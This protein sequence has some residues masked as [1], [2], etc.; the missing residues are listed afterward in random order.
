M[1]QFIHGYKEK[2]IN[3]LKRFGFTIQVTTHEAKYEEFKKTYF[4]TCIKE[5]NA[6]GSGDNLEESYDAVI[7]YI[8]DNFSFQLKIDFNNNR[9]FILSNKRNKL[10]K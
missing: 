9:K 10:K 1:N 5:L 6:T 3:A 2:F 4:Y 8:L 7:S